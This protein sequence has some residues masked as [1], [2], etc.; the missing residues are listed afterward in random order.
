[1]EPTVLHLTGWAG[2]GKTFFLERFSCTNPNSLQI[3]TPK[4]IGEAFD[5]SLAD[6]EVFAAVALD[7]V[8]MWEPESVRVGIAILEQKAIEN[9]KK[10]VL[11]TQG[12]DDLL[13]RDIT[14]Q[15]T[16]M[17][18]RIENQMTDIGIVYDG[19]SVRFSV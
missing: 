2:A 19:K 16:P 15:S 4:K 14:L 6:Y 11:V 13:H 17:Q 8:L 9:G 1:M 3:L 18:I 12:N 7:E 10:L 5:P